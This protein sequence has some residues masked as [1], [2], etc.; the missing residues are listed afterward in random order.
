MIKWGDVVRQ[1]SDI[2]EGVANVIGGLDGKDIQVPHCELV[3]N[4]RFVDSANDVLDPTFIADDI[5][6]AVNPP[7]SSGVPR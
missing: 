6:V 7:T 2:H 4:G 1:D 3:L 5:Q